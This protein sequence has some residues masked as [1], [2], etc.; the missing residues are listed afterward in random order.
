[1]PLF[2]TNIDTMGNTPLVR[3]QRLI[4]P[5]HATVY[6]KVESRNPAASVKCRVG[7]AMIH[8]AID[9]GLLKD[10]ME[11]IEPTSGNTGIGLAFCAAIKNIPLTLVM[12]ENMSLERRKLL[13][14]LGAKLVLT[15][16]DDGMAGSILKAEEIAASG[17]GRYLLL[18]QFKNP[19]NP[20]IHERTT[21]PEIWADTNGKIDVF[22]AGVGTGG[23][24]TGVSRYIKQTRCCPIMS[25]AVEPAESPVIAQHMS[26][27]PLTP[28]PHKIQGI[29]AGFIPATL[30]LSLVDAAEPVS[31][32]EALTFAK[33][34]AREEGIL[35]GVS[36]GAAVA[37]AARLAARPEHAGQT[38]VTLIPDSAERY[39]STELFDE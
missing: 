24:L 34:L 15:E 13:T 35:S 16:P 22:V 28:A 30:D 11:L 39:L 7:A 8:D 26:G 33:R 14:F 36:G 12:P 31:S 5:S 17:G 25:V 9:K 23:T 3:L 38:I 29:G 21:G 6:V 4:P 19:S 18:Q 2:N 27:K 1:M 37:V 32:E 10:G 20:A